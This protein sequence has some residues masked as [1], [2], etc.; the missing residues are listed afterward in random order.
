MTHK[1]YHPQSFN[2]PLYSQKCGH[3]NIISKI[4]D[5]MQMRFLTSLSTNIPKT[6]YLF[7]FKEKS[8]NEGYPQGG[9][10]ALG[11]LWLCFCLLAPPK[12]LGLRMRVATF[13]VRDEL[14]LGMS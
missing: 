7:K 14:L 5:N 3:V 12:E 9:G 6:G 10:W 8:I 11:S 1:T 4:N 2:Y 13:A